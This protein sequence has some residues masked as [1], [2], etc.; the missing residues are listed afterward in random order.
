MATKNYGADFISMYRNGE[1][2]KQKLVKYGHWEGRS[3]GLVM[4]ERGR[5]RGNV[6]TW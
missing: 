3:E 2:K 5:N 1:L 6:F 4:T